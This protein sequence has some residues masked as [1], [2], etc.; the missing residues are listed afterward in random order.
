MPLLGVPSA[1][2]SSA[3]LLVMG[4]RLESPDFTG[5]LRSKFENVNFAY[6]I[7]SLFTHLFALVSASCV[8]LACEKADPFGYSHLK[9]LS[10]MVNWSS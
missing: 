7:I 4:A 2:S 6:E 1:A 5:E 9:C 10:P 8:L 3:I